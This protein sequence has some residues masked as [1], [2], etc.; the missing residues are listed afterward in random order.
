[1]STSKVEVSDIQAGCS[2]LTSA[3]IIMVCYLKIA[4]NFI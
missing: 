1:M 4:M 3:K 2:P